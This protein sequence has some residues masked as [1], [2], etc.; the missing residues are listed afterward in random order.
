[1]HYSGA[2]IHTEVGPFLWLDRGDGSAHIK[3]NLSRSILMR[4]K[5][6]PGS[7]LAVFLLLAVTCGGWIGA[8]TIAPMTLEQVASRAHWAGVA[9]CTGLS[10]RWEGKKIVTEVSFEVGQPIKG[11]GRSQMKLKLLGGAVS[12]PVP[13]S[14]QV[15]GSPVFRKGDIDI[16]FLETGSDGAERIV[17]FSQGRVPLRREAGG[18]LRTEGGEA[19]EDLLQRLGPQLKGGARP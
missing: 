15:P 5:P 8:T 19:L 7:V 10:S 4:N 3:V 11:G 2:P 14:M 16:L 12:E 18:G 13:V 17:G 1:L 6:L 9:T